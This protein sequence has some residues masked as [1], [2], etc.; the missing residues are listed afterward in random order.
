MPAPAPSSR[1]LPPLACPVLLRRA[2]SR[3]PRGESDAAALFAINRRTVQIS[4]GAAL[5][6]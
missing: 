3:R 1:F 6:S 4:D 5:T 2:K